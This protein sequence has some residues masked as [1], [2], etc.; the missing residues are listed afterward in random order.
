LRKQFEQLADRSLVEVLVSVNNGPNP[1]P[2]ELADCLQGWG[3]LE[4]NL[5]NDEYD[6]HLDFVVHTSKGQ[7]VKFIADDDLVVPGFLPDIL[8]V[9]SAN[10]NCNA[11]VNAFSYFGE[12]RTT[13][14][15]RKFFSSKVLPIGLSLEEWGQVSCTAFRRSAWLSVPEVRGTNYIHVFKFLILRATAAASCI[16]W[17][18]QAVIVRPGAPNFSDSATRRLEIALCGLS[19]HVKVLE[20][21]ETVERHQELPALAKETK[22]QVLYTLRILAWAKLQDPNLNPN[23]AVET[24]WRLYPS[25]ATLALTLVGYSPRWFLRGVRVLSRLVSPVS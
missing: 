3:R 10:P 25:A 12:S 19:T 20:Y 22:K 13:D 14:E 2:E 9:L 24:A 4:Q 7:W 23:S 6:S 5:G 18:K 11:I 21:L 17:P 1:I 15:E 16:Y 8:S